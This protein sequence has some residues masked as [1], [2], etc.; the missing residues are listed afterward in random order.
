M[1]IQDLSEDEINQLIPIHRTAM[2]ATGKVAKTMMTNATRKA[3]G[4]PPVNCLLTPDE[5]EAIGAMIGAM[6][7]LAITNPRNKGGQGA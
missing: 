3:A 1:P 2:I 6:T 7:L 5:T 4:H